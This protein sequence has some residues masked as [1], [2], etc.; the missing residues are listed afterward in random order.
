MMEQY[1]QKMMIKEVLCE[2]GVGSQV[3]NAEIVSDD[4]SS[5]SVATYEGYLWIRR[6]LQDDIPLSMK[7]EMD[8]YLIHVNCRVLCVNN[9]TT[10]NWK[11]ELTEND[12]PYEK[13][14][15]VVHGLCTIARNNG[16]FVDG[17]I[18]FWDV[19]RPIDALEY[20]RANR[21][22]G[23]EH[24]YIMAERETMR[25]R[26]SEL[27]TRANRSN[28]ELQRARDENTALKSELEKMCAMIEQFT[29]LKK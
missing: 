15:Y 29:N 2:L 4:Q 9:H 6:H 17:E 28:L 7:E 10:R 20:V 19:G 22:H 16:C 8:A 27:E 12:W 24:G 13:L 18:L 1:E 5:L 11:I 21:F 14:D 23:V 25:E 3:R 26:I